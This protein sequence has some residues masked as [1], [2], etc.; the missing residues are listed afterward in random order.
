MTKNFKVHRT[1]AIFPLITKDHCAWLQ[2]IVIFTVLRYHA[3]QGL[4]VVSNLHYYSFLNPGII[5]HYVLKIPNLWG[6]VSHLWPHCT[7]V[8]DYG[9]I[10]SCLVFTEISFTTLLDKNEYPT[11]TEY[12]VFTHPLFRSSTLISVF[13]SLLSHFY[14]LEKPVSER[15]VLRYQTMT[16]DLSSCYRS[17]SLVGQH[18]SACWMKINSEQ[19]LFSFLS[20]FILPNIEL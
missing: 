17:K 7:E 5:Y 10:S 11:I 4:P 9:L 1:V 2:F 14:L 8:Q 15:R 13:K 12:R 20:S 6:F 16:V 3:K 19:N 18:Q